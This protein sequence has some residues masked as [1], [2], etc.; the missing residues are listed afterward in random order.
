M[1]SLYS[2]GVNKVLG[3]PALADNLYSTGGAVYAENSGFDEA[4]ITPAESSPYPVDG[5]AVLSVN[6]PSSTAIES[7]DGI[8]IHK[9]HPGENVS[10]IAA[11]YGVS[12]NTILAANN[13]PNIINPGDTLVVPPVSGVFHQLKKGE[14][15]DAVAA[16]YNVSVADIL[17]VNK[18]ISGGSIIIPGA[19]KQRR[20]D[21]ASGNLPDY[22]SYYMKP[23]DGLNW[24]ILHYKNAVDIANNCGAPVYAAAEGLVIKALPSGWNQG[25]GRMVRIKHPNNTETL[26]AHLENVS[27][28]AGDFVAQG[29]VIG[30]VGNSGNTSRGK[31]TSA[32]LIGSGCHVHFEVHGAKNPFA[33][34]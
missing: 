28:S 11:Q 29:D 19:T 7:R 8:I 33:R 4:Q 15:L 25:Y 12:L 22:D 32:G 5:G 16:L 10:V 3:G 2:S 34:S 18:D 1:N 14:S 20:I 21:R 17:K 27:I 31:I 6:N 26:Y 23:T 9:V 13:N 30:R 24:G